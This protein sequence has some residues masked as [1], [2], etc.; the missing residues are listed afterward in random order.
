MAGGVERRG[1]CGG[2][3]MRQASSE[4]NG[5]LCGKWCVGRACPDGTNTFLE[6]RLLLPSFRLRFLPLFTPATWPR[7]KEKVGGK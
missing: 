3:V 5:S 2:F 4:E 7:R 6:M 1:T